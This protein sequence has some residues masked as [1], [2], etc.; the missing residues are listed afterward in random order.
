MLFPKPDSD[1]RPVAPLHRAPPHLVPNK[2]SSPSRAVRGERFLQDSRRILPVL[3]HAPV[4]TIRPPPI[5]NCNRREPPSCVNGT[6]AS[7]CVYDADYPM[8]EVKAIKHG[9]K[10]ES[11]ALQS[12]SPNIT[13][14]GLVEGLSRRREEFIFYSL[15]T[16][17]SS[18]PTPFDATHWSGPEGFLCPSNVSYA[19]VKRARNVDGE[20]RVIVQDP[21][22]STTQTTRL[23]ECL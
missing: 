7:F 18:G 23:E 22:S 21:T 13:S 4:S 17:V 5:P 6:Q 12:E 10:L 19:R 11:Y 3:L 8:Y 14:Y 1:P 2:T 9:W 16:G 15:Y 20:W